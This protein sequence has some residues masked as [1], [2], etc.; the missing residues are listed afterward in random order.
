MGPGVAGFDDRDKRLGVDQGEADPRFVFVQP[1]KTEFDLSVQ[2]FGDDVMRVSGMQVHLDAGV[3]D[4]EPGQQPG[5]E[6]CAEN[7]A[8][9]DVDPAALQVRQRFSNSTLISCSAEMMTSVFSSSPAPPGSGGSCFRSGRKAAPAGWL[10]APGS[11][12]LPAD[13]LMSSC[14]ACPGEAPLSPHDHL[15]CLKLIAVH[16]SRT[17]F[18]GKQRGYRETVRQANAP[19]L[20]QI[21]AFNGSALLSTVCTLARS[22]VASAAF[23][24]GQIRGPPIAPGRLVKRAAVA[25]G[26][27]AGAAKGAAKHR[28]RS[29]VHLF[30]TE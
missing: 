1:A 28:W 3:F 26:C 12:G 13:W 17:P 21:A 16:R 27:L 4:A 19:A 15:E 30:E 23:S 24:S 25:F 6:I 22:A 20:H 10:P 5:E 18:V 2:Q 9:T 29:I 8:R 11:A 7:R 14:S